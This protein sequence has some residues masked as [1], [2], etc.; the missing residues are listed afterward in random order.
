VHQGRVDL[1]RRARQG[2][3]RPC[4]GHQ[5]RRRVTLCAVNVGVRRAID[6]DV[7][8]NRGH[9]VEGGIGVGEVERGTIEGHHFV[10]SAELRGHGFAQ[11]A[12]RAGDHHQL[13]HFPR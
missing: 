12:G 5:C 8:T 6:D 2:P 13:F 7:G 11:L 3:D 10:T 1:E 9:R 4:V